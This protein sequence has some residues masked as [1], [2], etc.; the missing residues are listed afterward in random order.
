[1]G[2]DMFI[3]RY[4][5]AKERL[6][7][8]YGFIVEAMPNALK[9]IEFLSK[10]PELRAKDLMDAFRDKEIKAIF[11][12]IGGAG[13]IEILPYIDFEVIKNNPKIFTGFSDTTTNH[14]MLNRAGLVSYYGLS[15]MDNLGEYGG[16]N[17]YTEAMLRDMLI[18]PKEELS[19]LASQDISDDDYKLVWKEENSHLKR[20]TYKNEDYELLQ[21]DSTV[22]GEL[23]GGCIEILN[24]LMT[25]SLWPSLEEWKGKLLLIESFNMSDEELRRSL[26]GLKEAHIFEAIKGIIVGRPPQR[27]RFESYKEIYRQVV[28]NEA[29]RP[30]LPILYNVN[31]GHAY[32]IGLF[33]LGLKY[34]IDSKNVTLKLKEAGT[35]K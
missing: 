16:I 32:P 22:E 1:M 31:V 21:G 33:G 29:K 18:E 25:T 15:V 19:I 10:H 14:F 26:R 6:E 20:P 7:K 23:L 11:S 27:E 9:G 5:I 17:S 12:A 28:G 24:L 4:K 34:E 30:D 3:H 8:D 13:G 35:N 2:E